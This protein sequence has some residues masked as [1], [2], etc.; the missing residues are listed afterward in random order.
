MLTDA[1]PFEAGARH[2]A[3]A[4]ISLPLAQAAAQPK[5]QKMAV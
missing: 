2:G 1:D 4:E 3:R 5:S